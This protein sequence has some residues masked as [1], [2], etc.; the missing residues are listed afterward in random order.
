METIAGILWI[1]IGGI[2]LCRAVYY[3]QFYFQCIGECISSYPTRNSI[4]RRLV[5]YKYDVP[6]SDE[7]TFLRKGVAAFAPKKGKIC[8]ILVCE[9]DHNKVIGYSYYVELLVVAIICFILEVV[10]LLAIIL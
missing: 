9:N 1:I 4:F 8:R 3:K 5:M 10:Y 6:D 7:D 2:E